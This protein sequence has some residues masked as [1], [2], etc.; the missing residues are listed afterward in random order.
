MLF[1]LF[2]RRS[3]S[4]QAPAPIRSRLHRRFRLKVEHLEERTVPTVLAPAQIR[5]AYGFDQIAFTA[6]GQTTPGDG[7]GQTIAIVDA[8][9]DP[10]VLSDLRNFDRTFGLPDPV[11]TKAT[12]QGKPAMD[13]GWALEIALDVEWAHAIA[14]RA[15][16]LLVEAASANLGDLLNAVDYARHQSGVVAVSMSWGAGEFSGESYYDSYFTTPAGHSGVTFV[17]SSGDSG[18]RYGPSWPAVSGNVLSV[19]GTRLNVVD[20]AGTYGSEVGWSGS[21]GGYSKYVSRPA[22]QNGFLA[23]NHRGNPDV[24]Y[25]GDP[26]SGVYVYDTAGASGWYSVA[27]T[28][29]GAPQWAALVAIADQGRAL[30]GGASLDGPSQTLYSLYKMASTSWATYYHDVT[31]GSNGYVAHRGYDLVTGLGTPKANM[32]VAGL[33]NTTGAGTS[34]AVTSSGGSGG[35]PLSPSGRIRRQAATVF[36]LSTIE[37]AGFIYQLETAGNAA[38]YGRVIYASISVQPIAPSFTLT[39]ARSTFVYQPGHL[40]SPLSDDVTGPGGAPGAADDSDLPFW[41]PADVLPYPQTRGIPMMLEW[42]PLRSWFGDNAIPAFPAQ[43]PLAANLPK[44][45]S[46]R[47]ERASEVAV[48]IPTLALHHSPKQGLTTVNDARPAAAV[49]VVAVAGAMALVARRE[50]PAGAAAG[51]RNRYLT[52]WDCTPAA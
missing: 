37:L 38:L 35:S 14:P 17:A 44:P 15:N 34:V 11:F 51:D 13:A 42:G 49:A 41:W 29:A 18:A 10:T 45:T 24:S 32:I 12:P 25:N 8:Y 36:E 20:S 1:G 9:D 48:E 21:G 43:R 23:Y 22:F 27:G 16:I 26:N 4:R 47:A 2:A 50:A 5:H 33:V 30:L 6:G 39:P 28:S 31:S 52:D 46:N 3:S 7:R 40:T 19:G